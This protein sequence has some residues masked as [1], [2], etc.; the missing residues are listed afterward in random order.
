MVEE[1]QQTKTAESLRAES[2]SLKLNETSAELETA[3]AKLIM[4][5]EQIILHQLTVKSLQ[6]QRESQKHGFEEEI[7]EYKEQIKQHSQTIVSLE[8]RLQKVTQHHKKIEE[9]IA[10]LKDNSPAENVEMPEESPVASPLENGTKEMACD[11]LI[12]DLL[13]AQKEIL[14]QQEVIMRLRRDLNEAHGRMSDLRGELSEKQKRELERHMDLVQQQSRE[15]CMLKAKLVQ[16]SSLVEKKDRELKV[17]REALR[18][19]Q[20]K[21]KL[22]LGMEKEKPKNTTQKCD[23]S[24]QIE[25]MHTDV[26]LSSQEEQSFSD[27]GAKCR[28]SRH[29]EVIQRQKKALSELRARI[30]ELEKASSSSKSPSL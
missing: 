26:F 8:E 21:H 15:L 24:V 10:T 5:E 3:K 28:G 6:D 19:S 22:H 11:H 7:M 9:E 2:L 4:M 17:L 29:E 23:I 18:T 30:K 20:D 12:D 13:S 27:L 1:T 25:P 14:S 16:M